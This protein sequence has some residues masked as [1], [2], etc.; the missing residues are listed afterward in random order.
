MAQYLQENVFLQWGFLQC[1]E[2]FSRQ[3]Y[4]LEL[5]LVLLELLVAL[6]ELLLVMWEQLLALLELLLP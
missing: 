6:L 2:N 3:S 4:N 1:H 5:R